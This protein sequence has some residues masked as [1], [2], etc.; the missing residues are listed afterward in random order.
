[1]IKSPI[2]TNALRK[3]YDVIAR[4]KSKT[5]CFTAS[6][7]NEGTTT[8]ASATAEIA[9]AL[10]QKVLFCDFTNYSNSLSKTLNLH[11]QETKGDH[12]E[13]IYENIHFVEKLG[14][15]LLP[16][17]VSLISTLARPKIMTDLFELLKKQ[18]DLIIIDSNS[19]NDYSGN[20]FSAASLCEAAD[21]TILVILSCVVSETEVKDTAGNI[22]RSGGKLIGC[23]MNDLNYP[24]LVD[25]L[26][27]QTYR[28]ENKFPDYA[29]SLRKWLKKSSFFNMEN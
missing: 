15:Y 17:P 18:Y 13:Q 24:R 22:V 1:M 6:T 29:E 25:E 7:A 16:P 5:I 10:N 19:I 4:H 14:F 26:T 2:V 21:A 20:I 8:M 11:F 28:L 12:L 3:L 27:R 23:V 9:A